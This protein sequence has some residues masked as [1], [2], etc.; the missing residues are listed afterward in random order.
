[1]MCRFTKT[2]ESS[3]S[4]AMVTSDGIVQIVNST[5]ATSDIDTRHSINISATIVYADKNVNLGEST[6]SKSARYTQ[7]VEMG[8]MSYNVKPAPQPQPSGQGAANNEK[9][10][11]KKKGNKDDSSD[12]V[13]P[14]LVACIL[15]VFVVTVLFLAVR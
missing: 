11:E 5:T 2:G 10:N 9:T 3:G 7:V 4:M 6:P 1:M 15:L 8:A 14:L 13:V 12:L